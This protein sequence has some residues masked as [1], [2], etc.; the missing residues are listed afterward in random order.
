MHGG[1]NDRWNIFPSLPW[2]SALPNLFNFSSLCGNYLQQCRA[3]FCYTLIMSI[4]KV[5]FLSNS[6]SCSRFPI[7][8]TLKTEFLR[9]FK[10]LSAMCWSV[11]NYSILLSSTMPI[12]CINPSYT[13]TKAKQNCPSDLVFIPNL[14]AKSSAWTG[15]HFYYFFFFFP[16]NWDRQGMTSVAAQAV[17][18]CRS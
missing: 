1:R 12:Q 5:A 7:I 14:P 13:A 4:L 17:S 11:C 8:L 10:S 18:L 2:P 9:I 15:V 6:H 16:L 3:C